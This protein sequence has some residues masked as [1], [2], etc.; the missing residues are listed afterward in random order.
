MQ[1]FTATDKLVNALSRIYN[2]PTYADFIRYKALRHK[3]TDEFGTDGCYFATAPGR[4][5]L[6]GNHT[7][8]N[9]GRVI[10]CAVDR[11]IVAAFVLTSD[12][13]VTIISSHGRT[14]IDLSEI[15]K[16]DRGSVGMVK[17]VLY[18]LRQC[19]FK[20]GGFK[21]CIHSVLPIGVGLSSSAAFQLL[22]GTIIN[23]AYNDGII[24]ADVLA[25]AGQYAENVYFGKPC[26]LFDQTIV[27]H[28][29]LVALDF[30]DSVTCRRLPELINL[31]LIAINTGKSHSSLTAE[32]AAIPAEMGLV[33]NYFG[34]QRLIDVPQDEFF[35]DLATIEQAVGVRPV[36]R[37]KHFFEECI[38]V[39]RAVQVICD[40][41]NDDF[42]QLINQSGDS[43]N[44]LL[45]NCSFGS[46]TSVA[47]AVAF[48]R[49]A[50]PQV[51]SRVHGGGFA[52]TVLCVVPKPY[53]RELEDKLI[54]RY[55]KHN[56]IPLAVRYSP[57]TVL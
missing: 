1:F 15:E 19:G 50:C 52:G 46:D 40:S 49:R 21:A 54:S 25:R 36:L 55:G 56:V 5:E 17:G 28:G 18:Y 12:E 9:G 20:I 44:I 43:S 32:Y 13:V 2:K 3:F 22:I 45:Q 31:Q 10:G 35:Q 26:G 4:V 42:L 53:A 37:A 57:A 16:S 14:C 41:N 48:A 11:D 7:D 33:A 34:K 23:Y 6:I 51:A 24:F 30:A 27:A 8:H 38:R 29:G 39:D 47:D